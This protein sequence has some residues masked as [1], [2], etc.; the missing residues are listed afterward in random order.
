[1]P[2]GNGARAESAWQGTTPLCPQGRAQESSLLDT[3]YCSW[4]LTEIRCGLF[5][6][7]ICKNHGN[8]VSV[9]G[10]DREGEKLY[11][12]IIYPSMRSFKGK[13]LIRDEQVASGLFSGA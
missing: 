5:M 11:P 9:Y 8:T 13:T 3:R 2:L 10:R 6:P 7:Y 1:M 12:V 4:C